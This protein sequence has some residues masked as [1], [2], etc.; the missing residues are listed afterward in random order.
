[1]SQKVPD[2]TSI[3][4]AGLHDWKGATEPLKAAATHAKLK[5]VAVDLAKAKDKK[6]LFAE[7]DRALALPE[8]FGH[9]W[10]ALADVLED[11]DWLG[12]QGR[13]VVLAHA[14]D[15]RKDHPTDARMLEEI[16]GEAAEFWQERHVPFWVFVAKG[17]E[18]AP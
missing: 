18:S 10:D 4:D 7:L 5:H 13:V 14:D 17:A 11:R 2:L 3:D 9:N 8:H 15:Y 12:K 6:T 16:L 1:M